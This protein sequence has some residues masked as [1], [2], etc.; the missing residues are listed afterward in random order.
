MKILINAVSAVAGGGMTYLVNLLKYLPDIMPEDEF[1][2]AIQG[3]DLPDEV[4]KKPNLTIRKIS[5]KTSSE[6]L[7]KRYWWENTGLLKLCKLWEADILYCIAN[8]TPI[9]PAGIPTY[10]MLQNVAPITKQTLNNVLKYEG[11]KPF[12]RM[13]AISVLTLYAAFISKKMLVLSESSDKLIKYWIPFCNTAFVHHG[14]SDIFKPNLS[15]P[16]KAGVE[17]YFIFVSNI[18]VYKGLEYIIDAYKT[19]PYLPHIFMVGQAF[20][21]NYMNKIKEEIALNKLENKIIFINSLPYSELPNWY[22]NAIANVFPSWC[23]SFGCGIIEAQACGCPVV[24]MKTATLPEFCAIP[25]LLVEPFD[26]KAL[27]ESMER[28]IELRKDPTIQNKLLEHSKKFTW[29]AAMEQH[30]NVFKSI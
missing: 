22:S 13:N 10:T 29:E 18:Y 30:K 17:P 4:Y 1:L 5:N 6:N 25:E 24:G 12:L 26:G 28:A 16:V 3:I 14:I 2:V 20:D 23:E 21:V 27:S 19:K 8:M 15:K 9:I 7:I 11:F